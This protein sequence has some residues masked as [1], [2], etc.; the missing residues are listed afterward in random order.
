MSVNNSYTSNGV[1]GKQNTAHNLQ[2][3]TSNVNNV[4]SFQ[5]LAQN[6]QLHA[7]KAV[8]IGLV[9]VP[10]STGTGVD[11]ISFIV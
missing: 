11:G 2:D 7:E 3:A 5:V 1:V 4:G 10:P 9:D 8:Y 6:N